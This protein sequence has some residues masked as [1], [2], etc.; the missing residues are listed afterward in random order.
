M[1]EMFSKRLQFVCLFFTDTS[2]TGLHPLKRQFFYY[3]SDLLHP[4]TLGGKPAFT[5]QHGHS[6]LYS[7]DQITDTDHYQKISNE[8]QP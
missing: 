5:F 4:N 6:T 3:N 7:V 2:S 8:W 1:S